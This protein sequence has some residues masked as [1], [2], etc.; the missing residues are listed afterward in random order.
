MWAFLKLDKLL[1]CA[2]AVYLIII[3]RFWP[4]PLYFSF[5]NSYLVP[6]CTVSKQQLAGTNQEQCSFRASNTR[7]SLLIFIG[8]RR[9]HRVGVVSFG[10]VCW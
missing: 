1:E 9:L 5:K 8:R 6:F 2:A 4:S 7:T 3:D 10:V